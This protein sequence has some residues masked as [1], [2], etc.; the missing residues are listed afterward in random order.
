MFIFTGNKSIL[1]P[2]SSDQIQR[3]TCRIYQNSFLAISQ[4]LS[5]LNTKIDIVDFTILHVLYIKARE[6]GTIMLD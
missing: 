2:V 1:F 5:Q 6:I 3:R 4:Q